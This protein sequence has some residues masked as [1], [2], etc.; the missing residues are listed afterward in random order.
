MMQ[1][2]LLVITQQISDQLHLTCRYMQL[3]QDNTKQQGAYFVQSVKRLF[4]RSRSNVEAKCDSQFDP[5][6]I[7]RD[8]TLSATKR[9]PQRKCGCGCCVLQSASVIN[10]TTLCTWCYVQTDLLTLDLISLLW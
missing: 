9:A 6:N 10:D 5:P 3:L 4:K 1:V 2:Q 8:K 7:Q